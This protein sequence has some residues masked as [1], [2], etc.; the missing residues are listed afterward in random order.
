VSQSYKKYT[1]K[2]IRSWSSLKL[3][4]L[5][6]TSGAQKSPPFPFAHAQNIGRSLYFCPVLFI[7]WLDGSFPKEYLYIFTFV[8]P[9]NNEKPLKYKKNNQKWSREYFCIFIL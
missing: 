9:Q 4:D 7:P 8:S 3:I 1:D 5:H 2:K 6:N